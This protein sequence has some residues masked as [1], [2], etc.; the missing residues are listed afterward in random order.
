MCSEM[1]LVPP[2]SIYGPEIHLPLRSMI[3]SFS[4]SLSPLIAR[5]FSLPPLSLSFILCLFPPTRLRSF[6][7]SRAH[8]LLPPLPVSS[9]FLSLHLPAGS[10]VS[11]IVSR[12]SSTVFHAYKYEHI[13]THTHVRSPSL[14]HA[15]SAA[16][17]TLLFSPHHTPRPA[18]SHAWRPETIAER[19]FLQRASSSAHRRP[20]SRRR[21]D[22]HAFSRKNKHALRERRSSDRRRRK[23][24]TTH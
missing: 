24:R 4:L 10:A 13:H 5:S 3:P 23:R 15:P 12:C 9:F 11:V 6:P 20:F 19:P 21:S 8:S 22:N 14:A 7:P 17:E 16:I 18:S 2:T 1:T